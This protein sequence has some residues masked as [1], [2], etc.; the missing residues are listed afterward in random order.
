[1]PTF[2]QVIGVTEVAAID[3]HA[4]AEERRLRTLHL[5]ALIVCACLLAMD[6]MEIG[7]G[8][9]YAA[10]F[11]VAPYHLGNVALT[12]LLCSV[13]AG[14]AVGA[15]LLGLLA[16]RS[17]LRSALV[18]AAFWLSATSVLAGT[19][20]S[21]EMLIFWRTLS[22]MALGGVPPL[23]IAYM[24]DLAPQRFRG[25]LIFTMCALAYLAPPATT[26]FM[27]AWINA[28]LL[29]V[30]AWRWP[31]LL[32]GAVCLVTGLAFCLLTEAPHWLRLNGHSSA[33][34]H[35]TRRLAG[36]RVIMTAHSGE[37]VP[38]NVPRPST[39]RDAG[40]R[41]AWLS[42]VSAT[43]A[44]ATVSFPLVTGPL[45]L[46][47]HVNLSD[48]LLYIALANFGPIGATLVA[49][50][51]V[52]RFRRRDAM[53]L[54]AAVMLISV[55]GF[56]LGG[57]AFMIGVSLIVFTLM[58]TLYMPVMT[59]FGAELF[60]PSIRA[61][62]TSIAWLANRTAGTLV[63]ALLIPLSRGGHVVWVGSL[64]CLFLATNLMIVVRARLRHRFVRGS[65]RARVAGL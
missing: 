18:V 56:V 42:A 47:R 32:G 51:F 39:R 1:M 34:A 24:T 26:F 53:A 54:C 22:G 60:P 59:T 23:I 38:S 14:A 29:G 50:R 2:T 27:R 19:S 28:T 55:A 40:K 20:R 3:R 4:V 52:D 33:L 15:P 35:Y 41:L 17:G 9:A 10:L 61:R 25:P 8:Q 13:F 65:V 49:G 6:F 31:L 16:D 36:S 12:A 44:A 11:S 62:A 30:E 58:T 45:L 57:S 46:A 37:P 48:T 7:L 64:L 43:L 63:P 21:T 5:F